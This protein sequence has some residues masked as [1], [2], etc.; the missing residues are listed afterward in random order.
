MQAAKDPESDDGEEPP[1][2]KVELK[3]LP[4]VNDVNSA[5][6][7]LTNF[8]QS[9]TA[10]ENKTDFE[11]LLAL[12]FS[13]KL[14]QFNSTDSGTVPVFSIPGMKIIRNDTEI[15]PF[16]LSYEQ[17][18]ALWNQ[19]SADMPGA[20]NVTS[21]LV[22]VNTLDEVLKAMT[23]PSMVDFRSVEF[24]P[25]PSAIKF[26]ELLNS[27]PTEAAKGAAGDES[28]LGDDADDIGL[29]PG[30]DDDNDLFG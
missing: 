22:Q 1:S 23:R 5:K 25:D 20:E 19:A 2:V 10:M 6:E 7:Y 29:A 14:E 11:A 28:I 24:V 13:K 8:T 9:I 4:N 3:L 12:Q 18:V 17:C 27:M 30:D 16:F 26:I 21:P 15:Q